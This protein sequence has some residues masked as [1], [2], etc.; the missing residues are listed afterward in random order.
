[1]PL[2]RGGR[3]SLGEWKRLLDEGLREVF[4]EKG[5]VVRLFGEWVGGSRKEIR[6]HSCLKHRYN[7]GY[8]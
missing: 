8:I 1:M 5:T 6:D 3:R 2:G 7:T 4:V